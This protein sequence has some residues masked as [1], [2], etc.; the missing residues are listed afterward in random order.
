MKAGNK[1]GSWDLRGLRLGTAAVL[2]LALPAH[3][4]REGNGGDGEA[5]QFKLAGEAAIQSIIA[6]PARYPEVRNL[7]LRQALDRAQILVTQQTLVVTKDGI[8]Q[9][10]V[11]VN[12]PTKDLIVLN[13]ARWASQ[14]ARVQQG[15][16]LHEILGLEGIETTGNYA[17]SQRFLMN[18]GLSCDQSL[19]ASPPQI[20]VFP[21]DDAATA[22]ASATLPTPQD[23][24]GRWMLIGS[25]EFPA[26]ATGEFFNVGPGFYPDGKM[27]DPAG[28][29]QKLYFTFRE[30]S[31]LLGSQ[32]H[33]VSYDQIGNESHKTLAH[34][35]PLE[36][37][38]TPAGACFGV[39]T[40]NQDS[41]TSTDGYVNLVCRLVKD[42][43]L[44]LCSATFNTGTPASY[45][46]T[47]QPLIGK[48][49]GYLAST[50]V[51]P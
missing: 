14:P 6:D 30:T 38:F 43:G 37:A 33:S 9:D 36:V 4:G 21:F 49:I 28:G 10:S 45:D 47:V 1:K 31:D 25:A 51:N 32:I 44:L 20:A 11:A 15:L 29:Y 2:A 16:A 42:K 22:F 18:A 26:A 7:D 46:A 13:R 48:I 5:L 12:Y 8:R 50:R 23:L 17:V 24:Q 34:Q 3:A 41:S 40:Y 39:L 27:P 19:C 35:G